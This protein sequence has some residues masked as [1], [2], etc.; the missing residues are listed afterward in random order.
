MICW[1]EQMDMYVFYFVHEPTSQSSWY[2]ELRKYLEHN[3]FTSNL[4]VKKG[5]GYGSSPHKNS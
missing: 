2:S 1:H 3:T 4:I 5:E